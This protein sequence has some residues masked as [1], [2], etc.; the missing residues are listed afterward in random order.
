MFRFV[1]KR[2]HLDLMYCAR[3]KWIKQSYLKKNHVSLHLNN[4]YLNAYGSTS[5]PIRDHFFAEHFGWICSSTSNWF[6]NFRWHKSSFHVRINS[7]WPLVNGKRKWV[8]LPLD[9]FQCVC[10]YSIN[11]LEYTFRDRSML[12]MIDIFWNLTHL[13]TRSTSKLWSKKNNTSS[14]KVFISTI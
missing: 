3:E 14:I 9:W 2:W 8:S 5:D 10:S 4:C 12:Y 1:W 6:V 7:F 13:L 11:R